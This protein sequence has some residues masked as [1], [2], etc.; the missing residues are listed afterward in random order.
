MNKIYWSSIEYHYK[1]GLLNSKNIKGGFVYVFLITFDVKTALK[2]IISEL[3]L[4][5]LIPIEIEFISPYNIETEW[6]TDTQTEKI[7]S[8]CTNGFKDT[9]IVF[10]TFH[11][12]ETE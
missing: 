5:E 11:A 4:L 9:D 8:I 12:Y 6:N 1:K 7:K 2:R 3:E 10:D